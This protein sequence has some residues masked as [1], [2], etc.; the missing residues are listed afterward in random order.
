[1][2]ANDWEVDRLDQGEV[3]VTRDDGEVVGA[4]HGVEV[5]PGTFYV[6][7]ALVR[8][9]R[10]GAGIGAELFHAVH[11]AHPGRVILACHEERIA[12]YRRLGYDEIVEAELTEP[13]REHAYLVKDLPGTPGHVHHMMARGR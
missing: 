8:E 13:S 10:R 11:A 6:E 5:E 1:M 3:W 4:A 7:S 9:D 2:R 12:F